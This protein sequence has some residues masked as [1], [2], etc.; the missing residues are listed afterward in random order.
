MNENFKKQIADI[1]DLTQ[2]AD[3]VSMSTE[4]KESISNFQKSPYDNLLSRENHPMGMGFQKKGDTVYLLGDYRGDEEDKSSTV[5]VVMD[6]IEN[7]LIESALTVGKP[8][9]FC[10]LIEACSINNLGF[11]ITS[12]SEI[13][14]KEF[15][16][17]NKSSAI[18]VSVVGIKESEF[19]D[20]IYNNGVEIMLLGH[21]TKGELRMDDLS[22]GY[23]DDFLDN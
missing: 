13:S 14:E 18:L 15:L 12:D 7:N 9:L 19:V 6:A 8:G 22:L 4:L 17:S 11:D 23:I 16:F 1:E 20:Y 3:I 2:I 10:A 5:E 21:I